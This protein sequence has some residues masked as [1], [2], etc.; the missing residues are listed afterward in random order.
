MFFRGITPP[1]DWDAFS[2]DGQKFAAGV[3]PSQPGISLNYGKRLFSIGG[4][5]FRFE[6]GIDMHVLQL[7]S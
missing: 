4:M 7:L 1:H 5:E 6:T 3:K 2:S